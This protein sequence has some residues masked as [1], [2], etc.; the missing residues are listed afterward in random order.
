MSSGGDIYTQLKADHTAAASLFQQL[1]ATDTPDTG[2]C[3]TLCTELKESLTRHSDAESQVFYT[4]LRQYS[5]TRTLIAE[6]EHQHQRIERLLDEWSQMPATAPQWRAQLQTL[7]TTVQQHVREEEGP[8][9]TKAQMV[10]TVRQAHDLGQ[11]FARTKAQPTLTTVKQAVQQGA[12]ETTATLRE[13]GGQVQ[14]EAQHL[15]AEAKEKGRALLREQQQGIAAQLGSVA[16]AL[17]ST[18]QH[19]A[20]HG[21]DPIAHY[22][23]QAAEGLERVS[24]NLRSQDLETLIGHAEDF[25]RRQPVAFIGSAA[26]LGFLAARFLKSSA[27]RRAGSAAAPT[28]PPASHPER[29]SV[30]AYPDRVAPPPAPS[31]LV[32]TSSGSSGGTPTTH[33]GQ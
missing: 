31:P 9:F 11:Q 6:S 25:A 23:N 27:A 33:G 20:T 14:Q 24:H 22:T 30:A 5:E 15:A 2:Q 10:L 26:V 12:S 7:H 19:L 17:R 13:M 18:A 32:G 4:A 1:L 8:L 21:Q 29:P 3:H 28:P 16:E